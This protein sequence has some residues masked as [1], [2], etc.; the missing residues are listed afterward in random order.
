MG[1]S[2]VKYDAFI[3]YRHCELDMEVAKSI[4]KKLEGFKLPKE[5]VGRTP[6]GKTKIE[7]VFRDQDELPLASNLGDP[8]E[9]ALANSDYLI[10][11]CTPRLPESSWCAKEIET[12]IGM[13]GREHVLAVLAEGEPSES[14][15]EMLRFEKAIAFDEDGNPHEQI[16]EFEPLAAEARGANSSQR[17]K[18]IKDAVLRLA[19]PIF[20]LNYDDLRQR[21]RE[22]R[23]KRILAVSSSVAAV[24]FV[25]AMVCMFLTLRI[26]SQKSTIEA[27]YGEIET[28]SKEIEKK[29]IEITK[30]NDEIKEQ[31]EAITRQNEEISQK[32]E[33]IINQNAEINE[34]YR[35]EQKKYAESMADAS[36]ELMYHGLPKDAVYA[37]RNAMPDTMEEIT[38]PYSAAAD[39]ALTNA[40]GLYHRNSSYRPASEIK[41][42]NHINAMKISPKGSYIVAFESIGYINVY[43]SVNNILLDSLA[44]DSVSCSN[45]LICF[46][47]DESF[48]YSDYSGTF[49]YDIVP[50]K[51]TKLNEDRCSY[52]VSPNAGCYL[53]TC[54]NDFLICDIATDHVIAELDV[55]EVFGA[56]TE[57][58][59]MTKY[60]L[61][62]SGNYLTASFDTFDYGM[63]AVV[64]INLKGQSLVT[65]VL[66]DGDN[67]NAIIADNKL[68]IVSYYNFVT[69]LSQTDL[70]VYDL[71]TGECVVDTTLKNSRL[72]DLIYIN[73]GSGQLFMYGTYSY[74]IITTSAPENGIQGEFAEE[75]LDTYLLNGGVL[76]LCTNQGSVYTYSSKTSSISDMTYTFFEKP[77]KALLDN[78][79]YIPGIILETY[80][81]ENYIA[82]YVFND[83]DNYEKIT[84]YTDG[85]DAQV[86]FDGN[87]ILERVS[88]D[89]KEFVCLKN[90]SDA[91]VLCEVELDGEYYSS[92][93][94][95]GTEPDCFAID[96]DGVN[97]Y[98][99]DGKLIYE[100]ERYL[101]DYGIPNNL[102]SGDEYITYVK[103]NFDSRD[104][105]VMNPVS[106]EILASYSL[107]LKI[108]ESIEISYSDF[109]CLCVG[110]GAV[111]RFAKD[112]SEPFA[113]RNIKTS[114]VNQYRFSDDGKYLLVVYN[115]NAIDV[116]D[117]STLDSVTS[118]FDKIYHIRSIRYLSS[119]DSYLV[120]CVNEKY[121][122]NAS[123]EP[124]ALIPDCKGFDNDNGKFLI[125]NR[126]G[127]FYC[128]FFSYEEKIMIADDYLNGYEPDERIKSK[129]HM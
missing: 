5:F 95:I 124:V 125:Y 32:N 11:I 51:L 43:D 19:A 28:K 27:Q 114:N 121:L 122:F 45:D 71:I 38:A 126:D 90:S 14:F 18:N 77:N 50:G 16:R 100:H 116:L 65:G 64:A 96:A 123:F 26:S 98:G 47:N 73:D 22:R 66:V 33:E 63:K 87:Y 1:L 91:S 4:Q 36:I 44:S 94:F 102:S 9:Q 103:Y 48:I 92:F 21:H 25:F 37:V 115:N 53:L 10:V 99:F 24:F 39:Y 72:R 117:A 76:V 12:F 68:F 30:Q 23:N 8:I 93:A 110:D 120:D 58:D 35:R 83:N 79:I 17:N 75:I 82:R 104:Y 111:F 60:T 3:S 119:I 49:R 15:P 128:N 97:V 84:D 89:G 46:I 127:L 70:T 105:T 62:A 109:S 86:S 57:L 2:D 41:C 113:V 40:L 42:D 29:N 6:N 85:Y 56:G 118:I 88:H 52:A 78:L 54:N 80:S 67:V 55:S 20:G 108:Y 13:H 129:Y 101:S 81:G 7:R 107:D 69:E 112:S 31:N 106:G 34:Q 61:D 74:Y 59:V